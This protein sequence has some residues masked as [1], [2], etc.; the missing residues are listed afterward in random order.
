[1]AGES[2]VFSDG[3]VWGAIGGSAAV[4]IAAG[5][6]LWSALQ[7]SQTAQVKQL[8]EALK[9]ANEELHA[10]N[11]ANREMLSKLA[12]AKSEPPAASPPSSK[13]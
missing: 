8:T 13:R 9:E 2:S 7:S 4:M 6:A 1:M 11:L 5:K 12:R 3:A 10:A